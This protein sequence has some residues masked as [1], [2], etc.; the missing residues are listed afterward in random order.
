MYPLKAW[1]PAAIRVSKIGCRS[2]MQFRVPA[3]NRAGRQVEYR[4]IRLMAMHN[5]EQITPYANG[6]VLPVHFIW[7]GKGALG[8]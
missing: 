8:V 5:P 3:F 2:P 7:G 1:K 4:L 6:F